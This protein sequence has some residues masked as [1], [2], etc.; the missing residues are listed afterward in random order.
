ML[1][2][3]LILKIVAIDMSL[4]TNNTK[5]LPCPKKVHFF[6]KNYPPLASI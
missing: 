2:T 1:F 6:M 4:D 3:I 5:G